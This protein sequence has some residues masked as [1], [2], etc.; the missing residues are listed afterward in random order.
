MKENITVDPQEIAHFAQMAEAWW[1]PA[2]KFRPLHE[3]NPVRLTFLRDHIAQHFTRNIEQPQPFSGLTLLDI[4][5]GGGLVCEPLSRLGAEVTGIDATEKNIDIARTHA[6]NCGVPVHYRHAAA[7]ELAAE[8][9][10][11]DIVFALEIVEHVADVPSF[12]DAVTALV[13]PGGV[14]FMST[15]NRTVKSYATA[16]I[17]AEYVL[18]WLPRGTHHWNK[19]LRPSELV[20]PLEERGIRTEALTG[21]VFD[22]LQRNWRLHPEKLDI[23]YMLAAVKDITDMPVLPK[24]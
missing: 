18:R 24:K 13:R 1:D 3:M 12:L 2:G 10:V 8:N 15:L 16:I 21:I 5:C 19:F 6:E 9:A 4:G 11:F 20:L 23:N 22:P 14:L 17:G 7:E